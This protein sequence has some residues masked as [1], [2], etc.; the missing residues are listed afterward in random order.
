[1]Q[2]RQS[3]FQEVTLHLLSDKRTIRFFYRE[4][5]RADSAGSQIFSWIVYD[6]TFS[7]NNVMYIST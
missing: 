6:L 5:L 7:S 3:S 1:M 4:I 2:W